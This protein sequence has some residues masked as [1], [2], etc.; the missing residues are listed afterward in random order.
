MSQLELPQNTILLGEHEYATALDIVIATADRQLLIFDQ[1]FSTGDFASVKR[2]DLIHAFLTKSDLSKLTIILQNSDFFTS[3]CPRLNQLLATFD[4]KLTVYEANDYAKI[5]KDCF[6]LSDDNAYIRRFHIDQSRFT[7]A[8][9][10][11]E[12][13]ASL[14]SRF[15]ELLQETSQTLSATKLGL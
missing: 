12:T 9:D 1:D 15:D 11:E 8:L 14:K 13:T 2:F 7:Y 3:Q 4:H 6:V 10:D 5:A